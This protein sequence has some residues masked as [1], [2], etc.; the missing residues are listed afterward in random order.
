MHVIESYQSKELET[1][2]GAPGFAF[3]TQVRINL[4]NE[5][6]ATEWLDKMQQHSHVTYRVTRTNKSGQCRVLCKL[7]RHCQHFRKS[8][9]EKQIAKAALA[10]SKKA[11]KPLTGMIRDKKTQCPSK[12]V[13]TVQIPTKT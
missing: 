9:T 3:E 13:L 10:K 6:E 5:G 7:E 11:K 1:F 4:K 12:L 8:L 2:P